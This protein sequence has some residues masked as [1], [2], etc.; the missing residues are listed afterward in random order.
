LYFRGSSSP[1]KLWIAVFVADIVQAAASKDQL[2]IFQRDSKRLSTL[3]SQIGIYSHRRNPK[4]FVDDD[5]D[6]EGDDN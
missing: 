1:T 5:Y 3:S 6:A 2:E 4:E